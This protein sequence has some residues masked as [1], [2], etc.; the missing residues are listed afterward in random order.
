MTQEIPIEIRVGLFTIDN[1]KWWTNFLQEQI[2]T[3]FKRVPDSKVEEFINFRLQP[4]NATFTL[5]GTFIFGLPKLT[6]KTEKD[7][8]WFLLNWM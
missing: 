7:Y 6:F 8:H 4:W 3:P 5:E 2:K 1:P